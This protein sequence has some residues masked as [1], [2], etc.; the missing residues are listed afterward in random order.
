MS[1]FI[2]LPDNPD[3]KDHTYWTPDRDIG[4]LPVPTKMIFCGD[5]SRGKS[6]QAQQL[7]LRHQPYFDVLIIIAPYESTE[8]DILDPTE[9]LDSIPH[10]SFWDDYEDSTVLIVLEDF[11]PKSKQEKAN[12]CD[13]YRFSSTH[14]CKGISIMLISQSWFRIPIICRQLSNFFTLWSCVDLR[15]QSSIAKCVG[16]EVPQLNEL[17]SHTENIRDSVSIDITLNSP[18]KYR[19]NLITPIELVNKS[20]SEIQE[21]SYKK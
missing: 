10:K 1:S 21:E 20:L 3:K 15:T 13:L 8:W 14:C 16:M 5:P 7:L 12:M 6:Y 9:V 19:K 18:Y 17:F 11:E 4:N 2:K